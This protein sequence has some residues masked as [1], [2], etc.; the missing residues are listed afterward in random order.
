MSTAGPTV[1]RRQLMAELKKLREGA[2]LSQENVAELLDW[3]ATKLMRIETGR[4]APHPSDVRLMLGV[5]GITDKE[6]VAALVKLAK[7]A[8]Q[9]GWWYSYRDVLLSRYDFFIGLESE[10]SSIQVFALAMVPGLLQTEEYARAVIRGGPQKLGRNEVD[11]RIEVRMTRQQVLVKED[12]PQLWAILDESV[13][14]RVIGGPV[15][16]RQQ[17]EHL[18]SVT[19][20]HG[21]TLQVVPYTVDA[22][23]GL[24]GP[25]LILG[26]RGLL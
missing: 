22:H 4:T 13:I 25:F 23:P 26:I 1:R 8:R 20:Q 14:R 12:P 11:G 15:V 2:G 24:A 3:H 6:Q 19:E 7:D 18:V 17:L 10:A 16:M 21:I 5:Y 9:R